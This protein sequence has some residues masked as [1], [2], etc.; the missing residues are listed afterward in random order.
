MTE[1]KYSVEL[2]SNH[3]A[4]VGRVANSDGVEVASTSA[5][6]DEGRAKKA[7]VLLMNQWNRY[8][9]TKGIRWET[10]PENSDYVTKVEARVKK[11]SNAIQ[12]HEKNIA[13][14]QV[15]IEH[16]KRELSEAMLDL[17]KIKGA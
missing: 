17:M 10:S 14:E 8:Y 13:M 3:R 9:N 1:Y 6:T 12:R 4:Y 15:A 5:Y 11:A 2:L 16:A 7:A